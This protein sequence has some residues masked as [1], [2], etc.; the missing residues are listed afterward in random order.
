MHNPVPNQ[1][2]PDLRLGDARGD[3]A[4]GSVSAPA[5]R[6]A[7]RGWASVMSQSGVTPRL[8]VVYAPDYVSPDEVV[9]RAEEWRRLL[10]QKWPGYSINML[11][12]TP[13]FEDSKGNSSFFEGI[14]KRIFGSKA[15][16]G[17]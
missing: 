4:V 7:P 12:A 5:G 10:G 16:S 2:E 13:P 6:A 17:N 11:V 14:K 9:S 15:R 8:N 3:S 1:P